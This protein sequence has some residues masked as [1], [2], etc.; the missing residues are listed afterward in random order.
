[1]FGDN[2]DLLNV[3][4]PD[5]V[6]VSGNPDMNEW[7]TTSV[8]RHNLTIRTPVRRYTRKTNAYSKLVESKRAHM[9]LY[10]VWCNWC[11]IHET[12]RCSPAME[13]GLTFE[14]YDLDF[15]LDLIEGRRKPPVRPETYRK[16]T[17]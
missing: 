4:G 2:V 1:M 17:N 6:K 13:A 5:R 15:I 12:L 11:R 7:N 10:V 16:R 8:E 9:N 3:I 14:L